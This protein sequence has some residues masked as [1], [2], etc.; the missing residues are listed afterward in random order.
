MSRAGI[1]RMLSEAARHIP[2]GSLVFAGV[3]MP[4]IAMAL[5]KRFHHSDITILCESGVV[6]TVP[7]GLTLSIS[8]PSLVDHCSALF[9]PNEIFSFFLQRGRIDVGVIGGAQVDRFGNVN[10]T[11]IGAYGHPKVRMP[12]SGGACE[13]ASNSRSTLIITPQS[14]RRFVEQVD[15]IT[16]PGHVPARRNGLLKGGGPRYCVTD[17]GLYG[18]DPDD[19]EMILLGLYDGVTLD[20]VRENT[21]WEIRVSDSL[22]TLG[23][24]TQAEIDYISRLDP[25]GIFLGKSG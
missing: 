18:F 23:A 5:A 2:A 16:S 9:T 7:T 17:L 1:E 12:G 21:G 24:P 13:I 22:Q 10:S 15:F 8:D 11:V 20:M 6:D 25:Q 4:V 19:G 3:G 14:R